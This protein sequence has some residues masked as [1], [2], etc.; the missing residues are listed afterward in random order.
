MK[1]C[2]FKRGWGILSGVLLTSVAFTGC[3][4][5]P[6]FAEIPGLTGG[7]P[8]ATGAA[9]ATAPAAFNNDSI[10]R[11]RVGDTLL[12][13][14]SDLPGP[15]QPPIE[16]R[17]R[18]NGRIMLIQNLS[19]QAAGKERAELEKEIHDAYVPKYFKTMSVQVTPQKNTQFYYV[20][21]EVR[22]PDRQIYISRLTV[23]KA[24]ASANGFTDFAHKSK[25]LLTRSDGR[26]ETINCIKAQKDPRLD[27][28]IYPGDR[29][30]V[31]RKPHPLAR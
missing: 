28:E 6:K 30:Q 21:G 12:I 15:L 3:G 17:V 24:I 26:T 27:P 14:F 8:A 11:I 1:V 13:T 5:G 10:D 18:D 16:D 22:K 2:E 29:I 19:F 9:V 25:V 20:D 7:Q 31:F 4:G 23:L